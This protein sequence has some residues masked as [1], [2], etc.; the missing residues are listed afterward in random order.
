MSPYEIL[1][2]ESQERMLVV[3]KKGREDAVRGILA[4]WDLTAAVIGEVIAEPVYRVTEGDR[5]VAEFPGSRLVTDCPSYSPDARE[6]SAIADLRAA[7]PFAIPERPEERD[8]AWTCLLY[9]SP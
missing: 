1:L 5:V 9:T 3:A 6:S 7:D 2:S 4:K 8:P